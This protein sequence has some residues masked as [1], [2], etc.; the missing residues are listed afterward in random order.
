MLKVVL[1]SLQ[2]KT[3]AQGKPEGLGLIA[4]D[5][6]VYGTEAVKRI[7]DRPEQVGTKITISRFA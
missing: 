4:N 7:V 2:P 1:N 5:N 3:D 6:M